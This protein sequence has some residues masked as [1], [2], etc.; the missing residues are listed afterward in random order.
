MEVELARIIKDMQNTIPFYSTRYQG[1]MNWDTAIPANVGYIAGLL[2]NQNNC[3]SEGGPAT[4]LMEIEVGVQLCKMLGYNTEVKSK[5]PKGWGHIT[6]GGT[7]ANLEALWAAR[8]LK[9]YPIAIRN[10]D[11]SSKFVP[12]EGMYVQES[13]LLESSRSPPFLRVY[14]EEKGS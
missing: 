4:T 7:V 12:D 2:Y 3:A 5:G 14:I 1:H 8:N 11:A 13:V 9:F 10:P 6:C